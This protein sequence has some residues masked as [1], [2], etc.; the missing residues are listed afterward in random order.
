MFPRLMQPPPHEG[1]SP[2]LGGAA[3]ATPKAIMRTMN[4]KGLTLFHLK[5]HLQKYRLGKQS[6]KDMDEVSKDGM[7][8]SYL[9]ESPSWYW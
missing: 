8:A 4:V 7:S 6:G 3:K 1:I 2:Q 9:L 5:S